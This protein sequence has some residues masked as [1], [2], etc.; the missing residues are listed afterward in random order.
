MNGQPR[1]ILIAGAVYDLIV[2]APL[3]F[4]PTTA[5]DLNMLFSI[6]TWLGLGGNMPVFDTIHLLFIS[7]FGLWASAWGAYKLWSMS[8]GLIRLDLIMRYAV[9]AVLAWYALTT[10]VHGLIYVF[11][12]MD[13]VWVVLNT[14]AMRQ[15]PKSLE[16][17]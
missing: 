3:A 16:G 4:P 1:V 17:V 15:L 5:F 7:L 8:P 9:L 11:I 14:W 2:G 12:A 6:N 10:D 13:I